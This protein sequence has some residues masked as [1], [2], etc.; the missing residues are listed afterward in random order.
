M[1][2]AGRPFTP[3]LMEALSARGVGLATVVLHCGISSLEV[4]SDRLE[5]QPLYPEP[6]RVTEATARAVNGTRLR[7]HRVV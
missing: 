1:P 3:R 4:E 7:G 5:D 2:S 6:F